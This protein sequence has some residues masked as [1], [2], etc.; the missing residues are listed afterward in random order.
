MKATCKQRAGF[1]LLEMLIAIS[2]LSLVVAAIYTS[3]TAILRASKVGLESTARVQRARIVVRV[4]E[5]S[6]GSVMSFAQNQNYYS[7]IAENGSESTL[8]FVARLSQSFPRGGKFGDLDVRRLTFAVESGSGTKSLVLRQQPILLDM[9]QDEKDSPLVLA[10]NVKEFTTEFWD[11]RRNDWV[12]EWTQTNQIPKLVRVTLELA[13]NAQSNT[14]REP[15]MRVISLPSVMVQPGW[16]RPMLPG[17]PPP[18]GAPGAPG[19]AP[20][21]NSP[22]GMPGGGALAPGAGGGAL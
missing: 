12:D 16:Q 5:D 8:S 11:A 21:P 1:T 20:N 15:I 10:E 7:F 9:D 4:L 3:W 22:P 17:Q 14:R 13:D 19:G 6:L 18:G 2:I